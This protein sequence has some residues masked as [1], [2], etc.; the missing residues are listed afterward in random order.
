MPTDHSTRVQTARHFDAEWVRIVDEL[1]R[2]GFLNGLGA[3]DALLAAGRRP[4]PDRAGGSADPA[5]GR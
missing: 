1:S 4:A 5:E 3:A 2:R